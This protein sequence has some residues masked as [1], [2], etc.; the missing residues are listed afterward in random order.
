M[1]TQEE[2]N[3]K[4]LEMLGVM[5]EPETTFI[6]G[7]K[8]IKLRKEFVALKEDRGITLTEKEIEWKSN[9]LT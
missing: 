5:L 2:V 3:K 7:D 1:L 6:N 8:R 4:L 9:Q